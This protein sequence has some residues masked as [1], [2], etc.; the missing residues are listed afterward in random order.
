MKICYLTQSVIPSLF[1]DSVQ[2]MNMCAGFVEAGHEVVMLAP[3]RPLPYPVEGSAHAFYDLPESFPIRRIPWRMIGGRTYLYSAQVAWQARREKPDLVF[4]RVIWEA[5]YAV[6]LGLPTI[7]ESHDPVAGWVTL[8][9]FRRF[10][11]HPRLL[12]LVVNSSALGEYYRKTYGLPDDFV[13]VARNA[14]RPVN[15]EVTPY[16][17]WPGRADV[18]QCGYVGS[19]AEGRGLGLLCDLAA[20]VP[21]ADFHVFGGTPGQVEHWKTQARSANLNFRGALPQ[22]DIKRC[23]R[24]LDVLLSP[25]EG[26]VM[27]GVGQLDIAAWTSPVKLFEYMAAGKAI[28]CSDLP[29][30]R[31]FMTDNVNAL[32]PPPGEVGAWEQALRRLLGDSALR[33]RLGNQ[34]LRDIREKFTW[35]KRAE[36]VLQGLPPPVRHAGT[37]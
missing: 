7:F 28:L 5:M 29:A 36:Q 34:A 16:T 30:I 20:R 17:P 14:S 33:E 23:L 21:E 13:V 15:E 9:F 3:D 22:K 4:S 2:S 1:A 10:I 25:H 19:L 8:A 31:E 26:K 24:R 18:L 12:R 32:M 37:R 6:W 27:V 11:R 35:R